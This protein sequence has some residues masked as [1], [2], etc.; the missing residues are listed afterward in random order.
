MSGRVQ[1]ILWSVILLIFSHSLRGQDIHFS[2]FWLQPETYNV[3]DIIN[4]ED[5]SFKGTV[6]DQWLSIPVP[7]TS[8]QFSYA[9]KLNPNNKDSWL[10]FG[11]N[12]IDDKAGDVQ[13][14]NQSIGLALT[15]HIHVD[16][17]YAIR[18]GM[19]MNYINRF[20]DE[21]LV[22]LGSQFDGEQFRQ[23]INPFDPA[24]QGQTNYFSYQSGLS[25]HKLKEGKKDWSLSIAGANLNRPYT[26]D[27]LES[28]RPIRWS[29]LGSK[30][31]PISNQTNM[32][33]VGLL[34]KQLSYH[35]I[36]FGVLQHISLNPFTQLTVG[37]SY[38]TNDALIGYLG[39]QWNMFEM[40]LS[41]DYTLSPLTVANN[42]RG[43]PEFNIRYTITNVKPLKKNKACC[44]NY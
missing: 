41:Y 23:G 22:Q 16:Q 31:L 38:R 43:G 4:E 27:V 37:L 15:S 30:M 44:P 26:N 18:I 40:G 13:Y 19:K 9:Q 32:E 7:Y 20:L 11:L 5:I 35:E 6:R 2:Q 21:S 29:L 28:V 25:V 34:Q 39:L 42:Y 24:L 10:A 17:N 12:L 1:K 36:Q 3:A 33:L 14:S 8:R